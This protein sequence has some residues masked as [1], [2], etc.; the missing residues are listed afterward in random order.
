[1]KA[2]A[3]VGLHPW[4]TCRES[5]DSVTEFLEDALSQKDRTRVL[6]HL[7]VCPG[8]P[9]YFRQIEL[10]IGLAREVPTETLSLPGRAALLDE[11]RDSHRPPDEEI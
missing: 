1:M 7:K 5:V 11:F 2:L 4:R 6:R 10:T 9:R 8:C 3:L